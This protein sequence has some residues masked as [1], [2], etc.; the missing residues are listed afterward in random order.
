MN[1]ARFTPASRPVGAGIKDEHGV[2]RLRHGARRLR[3]S[4]AAIPDPGITRARCECV[5]GTEERQF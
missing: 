1:S 5:A 2:S 3:R 4:P